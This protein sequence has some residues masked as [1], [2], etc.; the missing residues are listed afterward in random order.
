MEKD[1]TRAVQWYQRGSDLGEP[2]AQNSLG[3]CYLLGDGVPKNLE[4][5]F[6]WTKKSA[7]QGNINSLFNLAVCYEKGWGVNPSKSEAIRYYKLAAEKGDK[8]AQK[9]LQTLQ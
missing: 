1:A 6:Y 4:L 7:D 2:Y 3:R 9:K 5:G 8:D